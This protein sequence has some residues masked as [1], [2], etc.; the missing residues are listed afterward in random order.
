MKSANTFQCGNTKANQSRR[1]KGNSSL[2]VVT[3]PTD[4]QPMQVWTLIPL[5]VK[6]NVGCPE[7]CSRPCRQVQIDGII[8]ADAPSICPANEFRPIGRRL[9]EEAMLVGEPQEKPHRS[10]GFW[11]CQPFRSDKSSQGVSN[12]K[13]PVE[14]QKDAK[15]CLL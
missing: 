7:N 11:Q 9:Q 5:S 10:L 13:V 1:H 14:R 2:R 12:F 8:Q 3:N 6:P 4:A 15:T